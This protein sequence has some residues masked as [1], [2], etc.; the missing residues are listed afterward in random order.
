MRAAQWKLEMRVAVAAG[1]VVLFASD[2][3]A[4]TAADSL[5]ALSTADTLVKVVGGAVAAVTTILGLPLVY[6]TFRKTQAEITKIKL[7]AEK[8]ARETAGMRSSGTAGPP[9]T[10]AVNV[11]GEGNVVSITADPRLKGPLLVL[12]DALIASVYAAI[13]SYAISFVISLVGLEQLHGLAMLIIYVLLFWPV[14]KAALRVKKELGAE[15]D[16]SQ[17]RTR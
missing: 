14:M 10:L 11:E 5:S 1:P 15:K 6:Q 8:L 12:V 16:Q 17:N 7:E 13:A 4:Q 3:L 9:Q 2:A